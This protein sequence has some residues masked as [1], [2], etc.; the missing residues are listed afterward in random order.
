MRTL[1][2][3]PVKS[4]PQAKQRLA[5]GLSPERRQS[6]AEAMFRDVLDALDRCHGV[7]ELLVVT[8][9]GA[10][11]QLAVDHGATVLQERKRGHNPAA[12]LGVR[13]ALR[14]GAQRVLLIPGDCPGLD[15][16]ELDAL[17]ARPVDPPSVLI[18][19]DRHGTGTNALLLTP[20]DTLEPS[21]GPG[22]CQ[23]HADHARA[24]G[25]HAEVVD[26]PSLAFD[27]DTPEDLDALEAAL[28][29]SSGAAPHTRELLRNLTPS[30]QC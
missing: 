12:R 30:S 2:I 26:V 22:S 14:A 17:L 29:P 5:Q 13:A 4:F 25:V 8:P 16:A 7:D 28:G 18:V 24:A 3:L 21:F 19:P 10:P 20:P 9:G 1:A 15:P 27:V 23:R 6:L 11:R